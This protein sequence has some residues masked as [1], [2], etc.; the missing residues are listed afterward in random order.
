MDT[1]SNSNVLTN[2]KNAMD[3]AIRSQ[4]TGKPAEGSTT[5]RSSLTLF[6]MA[7]L[8]RAGRFI[9]FAFLLVWATPIFAGVMKFDVISNVHQFKVPDSVVVLDPINMMNDFIFSKNTPDRLFHDKPMF[10]HVSFTVGKR[11]V[12]TEDEPVA[13]VVGKPSVERINSF[14]AGFSENLADSFSA[15][16]EMS[17]NAFYRDAVFGHEYHDRFVNRLPSFDFEFFHIVQ[18]QF[19]ANAIMVGNSLQAAEKLI[20]AAKL[21]FLDK[22]LF[23]NH[24]DSSYNVFCCRKYINKF[25]ETQQ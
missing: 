19:F 13:I 2:R 22:K 1:I 10:G 18:D 21:I 20:G 4:A 7:K 6:G 24:F 3:W 25:G 5:T 11:V 23:C 12:P 8:A 14:D 16:S 9:V 15:Y 17:G